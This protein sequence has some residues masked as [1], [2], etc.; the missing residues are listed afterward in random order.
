M[1]TDKLYI[2]LHKIMYVGCI[3]GSSSLWFNPN[4]IRFY[5]TK[6]SVMR[7]KISKLVTP[8]YLSFMLVRCVQAVY[9]GDQIGTLK[10]FGLVFGMC[11]ASFH[12][13]AGVM[14]ESQATEMVE[15]ILFFRESMKSKWNVINKL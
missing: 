15:Q 3:V 2:L 1:S 12:L 10:N 7:F 5:Q 9:R 13:F 6:Y 11:I 4:R 14:A 8:V